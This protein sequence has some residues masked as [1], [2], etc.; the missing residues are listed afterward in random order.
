MKKKKWD[1]EN[2]SDQS[3]KTV[4]VT[5]SSSGIGFEAARVMAKKNAEVIIAVRNDAKGEKAL[6]KIVSE[7][8]DAKVKVMKLDLAD[9]GSVKRFAEEFKRSYKKLDILI[10][11]AGVMMPPYSKTANGFELQMGTN[12][13]GHFALTQQLLDILNNTKGSRIVNVSSMAHK[14]GNINFDDINWDNRKYKPMKSYGDSKIANLYFTSELSKKL[15][16]KG[17]DTIVTSAHPGWTA[18][19]LQR[20]NSAFDFLNRFFAQNVSMG[21]LPTLYAAVGQDVKSGDFYGPSGFMEMRG[22]PKKVSP[23]KRSQDMSTAAKLWE[24]SENLTGV[25]YKI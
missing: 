7:I 16:E 17:T 2:I 22:Y 20:H 6:K 5:G 18:T 25:K 4:I 10:N 9:L 13:L 19:E 11:N 12:H 3:G 1:I 14:S 23:N 8:K 15:R 24:V 21:T